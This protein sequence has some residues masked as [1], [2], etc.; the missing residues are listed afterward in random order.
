MS[1]KE[2]ALDDSNHDVENS[3]LFKLSS[4]GALD[5]FSHIILVSSSKDQYVPVHSARMQVP[6]RAEADLNGPAVIKMAFNLLASIPPERLVR[7]S[8]N[9]SIPDSASTV[10]NFIG[11]AVR[12]IPYLINHDNNVMSG[13]LDINFIEFVLT[14]FFKAHIA[15]LDNEIVVQQL[16]YTLYPFFCLP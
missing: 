5:D 13:S 2:L 6:S 10:D 1:L 9:N 4:N 7:I 11:R 14:F 15:F 16:I 8:V 3:L 12:V